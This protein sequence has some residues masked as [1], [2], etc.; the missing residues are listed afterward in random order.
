MASFCAQYFKG[1]EV[2]VR[3]RLGQIELSVPGLE[4]T[5]GELAMVGSFRRWA[6]AIAVSETEAVLIEGAIRPAPGDIST[7][8]VYR[9]LIDFTPEL[10]Y[11]KGKAISMVL[12]A[13]IEDPVVRVIAAEAGIKYVVYSTPA[14]DTC[15]SALFPR[16][17]RPPRAGG[18]PGA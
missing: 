15:I 5:P 14:T 7:L 8:Q 18:L 6:D 9:R 11:L 4:Y 12:V 17:Q 16:F 3:V 2:M 13:A 10:Q 1:Y